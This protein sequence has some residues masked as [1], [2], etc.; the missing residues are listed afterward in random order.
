MWRKLFSKKILASDIKN[1]HI[2]DS[3]NQPKH[4][5]IIAD[6]TN[7]VQFNGNF[8]TIS[9]GIDE[10]NIAHFFRMIANLYQDPTMAVLREVGANCVDSIIEAGTQNIGW[11]LHIP[12]RLDGNVRFVDNG[13]GI[14]HDQM[15][16]I[17]SIIGASSKRGNNDLIGGFGVG[18]WSLCS[19]VNNF[20]AISRFNGTKSQYFIS[21]QA[22]GLPDIRLIKS[23]ATTERNGFEVK[24]LCPD[25]YINEFNEKLVKAYRFFSVKPN[26]F[27]DGQKH[28]VNFTPEKVTFDGS[29]EN[30]SIYEGFGSP[31]VVM[32]GVGYR[33]P[34]ETLLENKKF[35]KFRGLLKCNLVIHVPIGEYSITP[36]R[37]AIQLDDLTMTRMLTKL[38][39]IVDSF[40]P[41]MQADMDSFTGNTW[42]AKLKLKTLREQ[43]TFLPD[44]LKL[45]WKGKPL[46]ATAMS[47]KDAKV[48]LYSTASWNKKISIDSGVKNIEANK[49]AFL[50]L[51]DLKVGG[52][53]R[54]KQV[55]LEKKKNDSYASYAFYILKASEKAK[56]IQE[57]GW[58]GNITLTSSLPKVPSKGKTS[59]STGATAQGTFRMRSGRNY[60]IHDC[61]CFYDAAANKDTKQ[62]VI[63][64]SVSNKVYGQLQA[65]YV[66]PIIAILSD[67]SKEKF[68]ALFLA[69]AEYDK[70]NDSTFDGKP[71]VK[72]G[73]LVKTKKFQDRINKGLNA[74]SW[75]NFKSKFRDASKNW[76]MRAVPETLKEL[77]KLLPANHIVSKA[78]A[79]IK[80]VIQ[81]QSKCM[82]SKTI[83]LMQF[84]N[85]SFVADAQ[86]SIDKEMGEFVNLVNQILKTYPLVLPVSD[87]YNPNTYSKPLADY[88]NMID[89]KADKN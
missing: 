67:E 88:I 83:S 60:G 41:K 80:P 55:I 49:K 8:E 7:K 63:F 31:V 46:T 61:V 28:E 77:A 72:F 20:Q 73:D 35:E 76:N 75:D 11:E 57:T 65:S 59:T 79:T 51:D 58:V 89:Q 3:T 39:Q 53:G 37:E 56:F 19:L 9:V 5:M 68:A 32:G 26:V 12:S 78:M 29:T 50:F 14:S 10:K 69:Q 43:F 42:E 24:F 54:A 70:F 25:R 52:V 6:K 38:D 74:V 13:V 82:D 16:R 66:D 81:D 84:A 34:V 2:R 85:K 48:D 36:S 33:L 86:A 17:Y 1:L 21:L 22:N 62:F 23:E 71:V 47:V 18:K 87:D 64:P 15:I 44:T 30:F 45:N 4:T 27:R 40:I